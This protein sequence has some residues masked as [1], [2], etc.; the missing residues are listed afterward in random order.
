MA[1]V[2]D[3]SLRGQVP[4][5]LQRNVQW[6][7]MSAVI[8]TLVSMLAVPRTNGVVTTPLERLYQLSTTPRDSLTT[9]KWIKEFPEETV[10]QF[11]LDIPDERLPYAVD[12]VQRYMKDD[13]SIIPL[14]AP[15]L[16]VDVLIRTNKVHYYPTSFPAMDSLHPNAR[17]WVLDNAPPLSDGQLILV[18]LKYWNN[19][20]LFLDVNRFLN[21]PLEIPVIEEIKRDYE[22]EWIEVSPVNIA[23]ARLITIEKAHFSTDKG[24]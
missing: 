16:I 7:A 2:W 15:E 12:L 18:D 24:R 8:I 10:Q 23:I 14:I 19:P 4:R 17:D 11:L 5:S 20:T 1:F 6:L 13:K 22:V 9:F 3:Q 21:Y